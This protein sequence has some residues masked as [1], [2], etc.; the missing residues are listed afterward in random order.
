VTHSA[1]RDIPRALSTIFLDRDGV[2]N[3]KMPEGTYVRSAADFHPLP[4]AAEAISKLNRA[5]VRVV[6]VSN[7]RGI[8]RG[9]YTATDVNAI[10][11]AFQKYLEG[12]GARVDGFYFCP[13]DKEQCNCRK[14]LPGLFEQALAEFP[15][16]TAAASAMLGDSLSD[17]EFGRR[18]GMLTVFIAGEAEHRSPSAEDARALADLRFP[19]LAEAV[20]ALLRNP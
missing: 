12:F 14:P 7:Q 20:E 4:G 18:L 2:L 6:V 9:L 13:H 17:I 1:P 11:T 8:A 19:S 15:Q 16:I 5:G 3:E 10:H